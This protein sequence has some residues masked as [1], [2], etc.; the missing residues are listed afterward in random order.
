MSHVPATDPA[1][2]EARMYEG[3]PPESPL[4]ERSTVATMLAHAATEPL[5]L[6]ALTYYEQGRRR[7]VL[8]YAELLGAIAH[9]LDALRRDHR[10]EPGDRVALV[11][12]NRPEV[13]VLD[14]AA[15]AA[16]LVVVPLPPAESAATAA[17]VLEDSEPALV[18]HETAPAPHL[19]PVLQEAG[20]P[21]ATLEALAP[22]RSSAAATG[23]DRWDTGVA[24]DAPAV[25]LYTSGTTAM[26]KGVTLSHYNL[27]VN[28]EALLRVHGLGLHGPST[29]MCVL[30]LHHANA[31]GFSMIGSLY[32]RSYLVLND[33]FHAL[34]TRRTLESERV[35]ICSVVPSILA[36]LSRRFC[37]AEELPAFRHFVSAA[38]PLRTDLAESFYRTTGIRIHHGYGLSECTNFA[39]TIPYDVPDEIY[40]AVMHEHG[41]PSVGS[42][43]FGCTVDVVDATGASA[44]PGVRGEVAVR[45]HN[46]MLGYWRNDEATRAALGDGFLRT[47]DEGF[48][49]ERGGRRHVFVTS[50][51][52]E[53][54]IRNGENIGPRQVEDELARVLGDEDYAVVGFDHDDVGEEVGLYV[55]P[56]GGATLPLTAALRAIPFARRPKVVV[57]G[58]SS[59]PRTSTGKIR[60]PELEPLFAPY[61]TARLLDGQAVVAPEER[62][63]RAST[64]RWPLTA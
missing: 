32:A 51:L 60:R 49:L 48:W 37:R 28:A 11:S 54:I 63:E 7:L 39:T 4:V 18:V 1:A 46:V 8:S 5:D 58:G 27:A 44:G 47:G 57:I 43:V 40:E 30:P 34:A 17:F 36:A 12:R 29:H 21:T 15:L 41:V 64:L 13:V 62:P 10:L 14:L 38:A 20:V 61:R 25:L 35:E 22:A 56:R 31:F 53:I 55:R 42:P 3:T 6:P 19:G 50:R 16:G 52:K 24:P 33:A 2:R 45:G 26:P 9:T 59:V 23:A